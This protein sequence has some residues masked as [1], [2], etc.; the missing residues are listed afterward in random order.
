VVKG[1]FAGRRA[2]IA[3]WVANRLG[4]LIG[5]PIPDIALLRLDPLLLDYSVKAHFPPTQNRNSLGSIG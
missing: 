5:L 2:L 3:E 4:K 1:D